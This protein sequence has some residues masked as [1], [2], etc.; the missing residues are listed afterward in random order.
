MSYDFVPGMLVVCVDDGPFLGCT[1]R[2]KLRKD[3]IYTIASVC[4]LSSGNPGVTIEEQ[5]ALEPC[6]AMRASRFKPLEE[7][8]DPIEIFRAMCRDAE[9]T[10]PLP[11]I[12]AEVA[13]AIARIWSG[14]P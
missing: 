12:E 14:T 1:G 4:M 2:F 9:S 3:S 13:R 5:R 11:V 6:G 7:K 8:P 10:T